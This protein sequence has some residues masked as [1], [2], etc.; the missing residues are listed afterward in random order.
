MCCCFLRFQSLLDL[1]QKMFMIALLPS[2]FYVAMQD[3]NALIAQIV[4]TYA[5]R[6]DA[7]IED[8]VALTAKLHAELGLDSSNEVAAPVATS[9][10]ARA[11]LTPE[12]AVT[13]DKVFCLCCGR[14]FK[15]LK[16]HLGAEH[17]LTE[18]AYRD[19]FNL[20]EDYPLVAPSYSERKAS[21]AR[22]VG[23]GKYE[24]QVSDAL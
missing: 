12:T 8:I 4:T 9:Y 10:P 2:L 18:Q 20:P 21:Y 22:S 16:R 23:F 5:S 17:G 6:P 19:T 24:R 15:M 11:N 13:N 1:H 7:K 3:K 14:G